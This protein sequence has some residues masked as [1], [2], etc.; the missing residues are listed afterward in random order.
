M[1]S[2]VVRFAASLAAVLALVGLAHLL[3]FSAARRLES[4]ADAREQFRLAPGGF[5]PREI[6]LD[7]DGGAALAS[8]GARALMILVPHGRHHVA[9]R[10]ACIQLKGGALDVATAPPDSRHLI[11]HLDSDPPDWVLRAGDAR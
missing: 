2:E 4:E 10:V 1:A 11:L 8:D 7:K 5:E 6:V 9:L 3:G